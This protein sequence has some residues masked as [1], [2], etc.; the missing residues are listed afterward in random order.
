[1]PSVNRNPLD[2][3]SREI[4]NEIKSLTGKNIEEDT[5]TPNEI[6][7]IKNHLF[8]DDKPSK[9]GMRLLKMFKEIWFP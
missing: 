7:K 9:L 5:F 4:K 3:M 6:E 1:M 2:D 8:P